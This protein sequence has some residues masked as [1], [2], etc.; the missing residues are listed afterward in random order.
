MKHIIVYTQHG[1]RPCESL[2]EFLTRSGIPFEARNIS[3]NP[4]YKE[5]VLALNIMTT[6]VIVIKDG[7]KQQIL[8][9]FNPDIEKLIQQALGE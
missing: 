2:K 4:D 7:D 6:P 1:C 8:T 3:E 9:G 5:E